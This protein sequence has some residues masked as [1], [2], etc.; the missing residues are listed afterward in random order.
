MRAAKC[1]NTDNAV[2]LMKDGA[3]INMQNKVCLP[4]TLC[5]I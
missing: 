3:D 2:E 1:G 4:L 5:M